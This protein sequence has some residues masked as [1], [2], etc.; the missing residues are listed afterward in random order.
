MAK[1]KL[2][3]SKNP[4][5]KPTAKPTLLTVFKLKIRNQEQTGN[6][7]AARE[8]L[9]FYVSFKSGKPTPIDGRHHIVHLL[10]CPPL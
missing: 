8:S 10:P 1:S 4:K 2:L 6:K 5:S 9:Q 3:N 7:S